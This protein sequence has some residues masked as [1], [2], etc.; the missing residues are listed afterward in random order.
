MAD[1]TPA[2]RVGVGV[3]L[4]KNGR[5]LVGKRCVR[6]GPVAVAARDPNFEPS[7]ARLRASARCL[8]AHCLQAKRQQHA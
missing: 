2:V 5:V 4:F 8:Q 6:A 7:T 1:S 3:I